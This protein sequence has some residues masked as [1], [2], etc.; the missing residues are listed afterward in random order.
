MQI[1]DHILLVYLCIQTKQQATK[2]NYCTYVVRQQSPIFEAW[3]PGW[4]RREGNHP[5]RAVGQCACMYVLAHHLCR[6]SCACM[7]VSTSLPLTQVELCMHAHV[8]RPTTHVNGAAHA[9]VC[10]PT[11]HVRGHDPVVGHGPGIEDAC[12]KPSRVAISVRWDTQKI[13]E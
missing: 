7:H 2:Y 4:G 11:C 12:C 10:Q 5:V 13:N 1:S 3:Q 9:H 6:W 8:H